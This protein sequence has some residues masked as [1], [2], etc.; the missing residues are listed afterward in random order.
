MDE[1]KRLA[2]KKSR[3]GFFNYL[4]FRNTA[5]ELAPIQICRLLGFTGPFPSTTLDKILLTLEIM[6][7]Q[8]G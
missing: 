7:T 2:T 5:G 4:I 6:I 8:H 1:E 3:K